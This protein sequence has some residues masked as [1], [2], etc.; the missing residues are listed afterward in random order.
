MRIACYVLAVF[1]ASLSFAGLE[2]VKNKVFEEKALDELEGHLM[3]EGL[4]R[5]DVEVAL[6][7]KDGRKYVFFFLIKGHRG[8][9]DLYR[10][11]CTKTKCRFHYN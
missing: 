1:F 3:N 6:S 5:E 8:K 7:Y 9:E 11:F 2:P 4:T 10:V